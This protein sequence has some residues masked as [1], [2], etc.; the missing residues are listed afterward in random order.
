MKYANIDRLVADRHATGFIGLIESQIFDAKSQPYILDTERGKHE[1]AK[2][3][4]SFLNADGGFILIGGVTEKSATHSGEEVTGISWFKSELLNVRRY[5][6]IINEWV[7]P[8]PEG[9]ELVEIKGD[10]S[11][12]GKVVFILCARGNFGTPMANSSAPEW[13]EVRQVNGE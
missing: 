13:Q 12:D 1:L 8:S 6:D 10:Q 4:V 5:Y 9:V 2:D 11:N 7:Y 3:I